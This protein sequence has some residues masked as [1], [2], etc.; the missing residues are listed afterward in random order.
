MGP[1]S[2]INTAQLPP[3]QVAQAAD[4]PLGHWLLQETSGT[5]CADISGNGRDATYASAIT[6]GAAING[7]GSSAIVAGRAATTHAA[8]QNVGD[9]TVEI[10]CYPTVVTGNNSP[11]GRNVSASGFFFI[12]N[13]TGQTT[14]VYNSAE[15]SYNMTGAPGLTVNTPYLLALRWNSTTHLASSWKNG[16]KAMEVATTSTASIPSIPLVI[17]A[18]STTG[19]YPWQGRLSFAAFYGTALSDARLL[20]H[21]Q[22]AG[23]A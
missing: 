15:T 14:Y 2:T 20:A 11:I 19:Q 16:V 10:L 7:N 18:S 21:A 6:S 17:G 9:Y 3:L 12:W 13:S 5:L 8:W 4:S 22:A 1:S 23:L